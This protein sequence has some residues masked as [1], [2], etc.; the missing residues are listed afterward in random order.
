MTSDE[1]L[2]TDLNASDS[3]TT[4][5]PSAKQSSS[6]RLLL[7]LGVLALMCGALAFDYK[8]ARPSVQN[9]H[10]AV[11]DLNV[12]HNAV[13][14]FNVM[15]NQMVEEIVGKPPA[16]TFKDGN[17][18][19]EVYSWQSGLPFR[20]YKLYAVYQT[21]GKNLMLF[22]L[23]KFNYELTKDV[24]P[25]P[26]STVM[27]ATT[28]ELAAYKIEEDLAA[29]ESMR[30]LEEYKSSQSLYTPINVFKDISP[31]SSGNPPTGI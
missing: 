12:M 5:T 6:R 18:T 10:D 24:I 31:K 23:H 19:V 14:Q 1:N 3:T 27:K 15:T 9:A 30:Y 11:A 25:F 21:V 29:M 17:Y 28:E 22:R 4:E 26:E 2:S 8:V 20:T 16:D 7:L 13:P